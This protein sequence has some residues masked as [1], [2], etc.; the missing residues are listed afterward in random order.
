[1]M[2]ATGLPHVTFIMFRYSF[3][4]QFVRYFTFCT[5]F[6]LIWK[7]IMYSLV[8]LLIAYLPQYKIGF[9]GDKGVIYPA[10]YELGTWGKLY[11][12]SEP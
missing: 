12:L 6:V 7:C 9:T 2:L 10:R 4:T 8:Y 3:Y 11:G 5:V 1:M